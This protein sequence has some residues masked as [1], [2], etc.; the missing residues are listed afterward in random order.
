MRSDSNYA[1]IRRESVYTGKL[2]ILRLTSCSPYQEYYDYLSVHPILAG[3]T[4]DLT[5]VTDLF[6]RG[7]LIDFLYYCM[8]PRTLNAK[9][10]K[11]LR[12]IALMK[13]LAA[14]EITGRPY[15]EFLESEEDILSWGFSDKTK[16]SVFFRIFHRYCISRDDPFM[17]DRWMLADFNLSADRDYNQRFKSISFHQIKDE[18]NK[19]L[20]K[21]YIKYC[22]TNTGVSVATIRGRMTSLTSLNLINRPF[23][24]WDDSDAAEFAAKLCERYPRRATAAD[25]MATLF[26]F[27]DFL[28][29]HDYISYNPVKKYK[30]L[31]S[32]GAFKH[33]STSTDSNVIA[34]IFNHLDKLRD[35][36][37]LLCFLLIFCTGMRSSEACSIG[38]DC[39][40]KT[41]KG[42]FVKYYSM[43]M[44]K[45]T[46]NI[47]PESLYARLEAYKKTRIGEKFLFVVQ[48]PYTPMH[49]GFFGDKMNEFITENGIR[50]PDG[51]PYTFNA[52]SFRHTM[53]VRMREKNIPLQVIQ[54]Q[55]HHTSPDM[56]LAYV[57]YIDRT[58]VKK[59]EGFI[60]SNGSLAEFSI[61]GPDDDAPYLEYM[62][63][64][65]HAQMLPDGLC[66]RPVKLGKCSNANACLTCP[67]FRT[68]CK[69]LPVHQRHLEQVKRSLLTAEKNGWL[70]QIASHKKTKQTLEQIIERLESLNHE[71]A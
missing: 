26:M 14:E 20:V 56:T 22:L 33:C 34:M 27:T 59:M 32:F 68:S 21:R 42:Y 36:R 30:S 46:F 64:Y 5:P 45:V 16:V 4:I 15:R 29:L 62:T 9:S 54:E 38:V 18:R 53:A 44:K 3:M 58:R 50:N 57:E 40:E 51:S 61:E 55:L 10:Y 43:K 48:N 7:R 6:L 69:D 63:K 17:S 11:T 49:P 66:A 12:L 23:E 19:I 13:M 39:T 24:E 37:I 28:L 70:P 25:R 31:A 41:D 71:H 35:E 65:L 8:E 47:I 67:D 2:D 60:D 52:H 1:S